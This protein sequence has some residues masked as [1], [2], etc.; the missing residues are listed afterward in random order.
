MRTIDIHEAK[1]NL[2]NLIEQ[3]A[4]GQSFLIAISGTPR[5]MVLPLESREAGHLRRVGLL[6][7]CWV[8]AE[9]VD[10]RGEA[11]MERLFR[12]S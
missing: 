7:R 8:V 5:V 6:E 9:E 1:A 3:A 12:E 4:R 2:F 11:N 10:P